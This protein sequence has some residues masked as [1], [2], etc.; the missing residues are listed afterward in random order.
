MATHTYTINASKCAIIKAASPGTHAA[1]TET[2]KLDADSKT[3]VLCEFDLSSVPAGELIQGVSLDAYLAS[4]TNSDGGA[5]SG[6]VS[7]HTYDEPFD[8]DTVVWNDTGFSAVYGIGFR[9]SS[10]NGKSY[11]SSNIESYLNIVLPSWKNVIRYVLWNDNNSASYSQ[12]TINTSAAESN[13]LC[14]TVTTRDSI[15]TATDLKP[16]QAF[17]DASKVQ[18]VSWTY[19]NASGGVQKSFQ[20]QKSS[21]NSTWS[22]VATVTSADAFYNLPEN[23]FTAGNWYWRV[24]VTSQWDIAGDWSASA[25][26]VAQADPVAPYITSV[27]DSPRPVV[28]WQSDGQQAYQLQAGDYTSG[29]VYGT[30]KTH[31][32]PVY[33]PDGLTTIKLRVQ[34]AFGLWSP[35][36]EVDTTITHTGI[37]AVVLSA[38][39]VNSE[40]YLSWTGAHDVYYIYRDNELIAKTTEKE[41]IDRLTIGE[42]T[43]KARGAV[44]DAYDISDAVAVTSVCKTA[45]MAEIGAYDWVYLYSRRGVRPSTSAAISQQV[46]YQHYDGRALPVADIAEYVDEAY[47]L[48]YAFLTI[49]EA[50]KARALLGKTVIFKTPRGER[51]I[52]VLESMPYERDRWSTD[53]TF[54]I[55]AIDYQ[56]EV[57][58]DV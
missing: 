39:H 15:P 7:Y 50:D 41:Y 26:V 22:D 48:C 5:S 31:T 27:S 56:P 16:S 12:P 57:T 24:K 6:A 51:I 13:K 28:A 11:N 9:Y 25:L 29:T 20:I 36:A 34:N 37:V 32:I 42:H 40:V 49:E 17:M 3:A 1:L 14:I 21:D 30:A 55:R 4:I 8:P 47:T 45:M 2:V 44:G 46:V 58:Y 38:T 54:T 35:W 10:W 53:F 43:Y 18:R 19:N 52:G 23:T 33:L